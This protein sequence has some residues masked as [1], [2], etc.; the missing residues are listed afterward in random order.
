MH[1]VV[2]LQTPE[3][4]D[5]PGWLECQG[6]RL[7]LACLIGYARLMFPTQVGQKAS[8]QFFPF[9]HMIPFGLVG[10]HHPST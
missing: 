2:Q 7:A 1:L 9:V 5:E 10:P 8:S 4:P 6:V 3:A